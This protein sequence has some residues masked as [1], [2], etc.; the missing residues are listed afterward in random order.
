[1]ST[2]QPKA[3]IRWTRL[4][5]AFSVRLL[6]IE[7][8]AIAPLAVAQTVPDAYKGNP[9]LWGGV[10]YA[11]F[12]AGFPHGSDARISGIGGL[13]TFVWT[14]SFGL[15]GHFR[16]LDMN[17]WNGET[18]HDYLAGPRYT[19]L[20]GDTWRPYAS[21]QVGVVRMQ[22]PFNIGT[23]TMFAAVP[24][25]GLEYRLS[26]RW[27]VRAAYEYQIL[28]NSPNFTD[29]PHFGMRPN[30]PYGGISYRIR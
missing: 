3:W 30:G 10:E 28:P 29:E 11:N 23:G 14:R 25:G 15:E 6:T 8:L 16:Y 5:K 13:V 20:H 12:Y 7:L 24:E 21:F 19:F 2:V 9:S 27:S 4:W 17:S 1:M 26:H 22:Y 18:E